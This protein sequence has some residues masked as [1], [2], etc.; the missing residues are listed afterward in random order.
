MGYVPQA[1][2]TKISYIMEEKKVYE[3]NRER[4]FQPSKAHTYYLLFYDYLK[5]EITCKVTRKAIFNN[6]RAMMA[7]D[8]SPET[9]GPLFE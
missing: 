4:T 8:R 6:K 5:K 9:L 7:L 1:K 2:K 3:N